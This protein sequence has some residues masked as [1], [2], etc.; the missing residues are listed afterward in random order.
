LERY[1]CVCTGFRPANSRSGPLVGAEC[2]IWKSLCQGDQLGFEAG[3]T[4]ESQSM[5]LCLLAS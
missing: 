5:T 4:Q 3:L 2:C 1:F